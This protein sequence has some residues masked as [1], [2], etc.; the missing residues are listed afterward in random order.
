MSVK[1]K[2][3]QMK[4]PIRFFALLAL[5]ACFAFTMPSKLTDDAKIINVVIDA[6]H[7]GKDLG[8]THDD[9]TEKQI[10]DQIA[11]KIMEMNTDSEVVIHFT[12]EGDKF[13][14][15][16]KRVEAINAIKP[17][18]V[19]SLHVNYTKHSSE[20]SGMEFFICKENKLAPKAAM[21]AERLSDKFEN[22]GFKVSDVK[23]APFFT[24]LKS[25]SPAIMVE[26]GY[27]SNEIDRNYLTSD[28]S[29]EE[30]A[31]IVADFLKEL[32]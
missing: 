26:L 22:K 1:P 29:Q 25:Q 3:N 5:G 18:L 28:K 12:R 32:K 14:D 17:D 19:I 16:N 13:V 23:G 10:T 9:F 15:L 6:G 30:I 27:L 21:F 31:G 8:A 2:P 20:R 11:Y 24:L 4:K 7:G